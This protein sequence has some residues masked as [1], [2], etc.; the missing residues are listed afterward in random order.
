M[1][2]KEFKL[3]KLENDN[4]VVWKW[5]FKN[6]INAKGWQKAFDCGNGN[7][8]VG[9]Q[10]L[11]LLGSALS[12]ENILKI[13]N[14]GTFQEA[15]KTIESCY[16][17]KTAYEPQS[18]YRRLNSYK[19]ESAAEISS[20][21][22]EIK[23][24]VAQLQNLGETVSENCVIGSILSALPSSF[25][26]FVTV[27]RNSSEKNVD[28]LVSKLMAE[29]NDQ[30]L[31]NTEEVK[32]LAAK[33]KGR[34]RFDKNQCRY[35]KQSGHWIK[36][37]PN[38][39]TP[40]DPNRNKNKNGQ[41]K[42]KKGEDNKEDPDLAFMSKV[43]TNQLKS[44][45][46]WVAD[47][48]CTNHMSPF[49]H[50][51]EKLEDTE[52]GEENISLA[53]DKSN[54]K[55]CGK[56]EI[57]T[58]KGRLKDVWYVPELGQ[59]LFSISAAAAN[60][61]TH[62]G[63]KEKLTFFYGNRE[64]FSA[65]LKNKL[66]LIRL[67][68]KELLKATANSATLKEWHDRFSHVPTSV[69]KYMQ[70]HKIVEDL[71][72]V[73]Q[74]KDKCED[75]QLNK[76]TKAHHP[77]RTTSKAR[78]A[79]NVLH[80]D[81]AGPSNVQSRS[82]SKY[83]VLCKDEASRYRQVA[84]VET[85][86]QIKDKVKKFIS[87]TMLETG[88]QV[89]K[90]VTDNGSEYVNRELDSYLQG[91]GIIHE[92]SVPYVPAQNGY[93]EREIRTIKE[94]AKT[95]LN[96]SK[97]N[98]NLWPEAISCAVYSLN[99]TINS[100]NNLRTPYEMWF[101]TKPSVKN[102]RIFGQLAILRQPD[103][104]KTTTWHQ[105]GVKAAFLGYTDRVNTYR[106][107]VNDKVIV[108][109]DARFMNQMYNS[110]PRKQV[111]R[112]EI[113]FWVSGENLTEVEL[114]LNPNEAERTVS[115]Q[116]SVAQS[117]NVEVI[118][119][120]SV[121]NDT[122]FETVLSNQPI[123]STPLP[124]VNVTNQQSQ[125]QEKLS[126]DEIQMF[127]NTYPDKIVEFQ[128]GNTNQTIRMKDIQFYSGTYNWKN[129]KNGQF[130][131]NQVLRQI[132]DQ[133]LG[134][135]ANTARAMLATCVSIPTTYKEAVNSEQ[136]ADW[137]AA[138]NEEMNS[139]IKNEVFEVVPEAGI[140]KKVVGSR[141]VYTIKYKPND[142]I[143][144]FKARIV[145]K[146]YT[147]RYGIDYLET[148][149][150]V[151]HV[152][153]IRLILSY[154][155]MKRLHMRQFDVKTAFLYG[156]LNE[157]IF[158]LPPEG[159][160]Q[161]NTVWKL[162]RSMYGLK[163]SPRMWNERFRKFM[164]NLGLQMSNY[165]NS[166]FYQLQPILIVI[167]YVD[168]GVI[169]AENETD[170]TRILSELEN[171]F[172]M[173]KLE[174]NI[175]RGIQIVIQEDGIFIH[176]AKYAHKVLKTFNMLDANKANNPVIMFMAEETLLDGSVPYRNAVGSL[177]YLA[178][179]TRPDIA[180]AVNQLT[181]KSAAPTTSD[182]KK[183][184]HVLRYLKG[185]PNLGIKFKSEVISENLIGYCDS[186]FSGCV[187]TSKSTT[188]YVILFNNSPFHWKTQLQKHVTLSSTEAEVIALCALSKELSW[189]R[190][191]IMELGMLNENRAII[192]CDNQSAITI[193]KSERATTRTRHLRAQDAYVREQIELQELE[194][195]HVKTDLQLADLLTKC[196]NTRKF[197][198]NCDKLLTM[199]E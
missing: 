25:D 71:N 89:L 52:H 85:K 130:L 79:G 146:G 159:Y 62:V 50:L 147:Q 33:Y 121:N 156:Q 19:I 131:S 68:P 55:V 133:V 122:Q 41:G 182:W 73:T 26:I 109:C 183:V 110:E 112:E 38:L 185:T 193:A 40:Y 120:L 161:P 98:E 69:I 28:S 160:T 137:K 72:I 124:G 81:T 123:S 108:S 139:M 195:K 142:E 140:A 184:K 11:G 104:S 169:F 132:R 106:F 134:S 54:L 44:E 179:T 162:K 198:E 114:D 31:K 12:N 171:E 36:D 49:K 7:E 113:D 173:R 172:E 154:A 23:G 24:I 80:L 13:I 17:N 99:R 186:D 141:W 75:C 53:D 64:L 181:R 27:W 87:K 22:S 117:T 199:L 61:L 20:G 88:N 127:I 83:F 196:V 151:V 165:D 46:I 35:C 97:L 37:C 32:A 84:F 8:M 18:L 10:A 115:Q 197:K 107:L 39:K 57:I 105:K 163:Q 63:G 2:D 58:R 95:M 155:A 188:G 70:K 194:L 170:I 138:M 59:N 66:Y 153:S 118:Q 189:I 47:S 48:G 67:E 42:A 1:G 128:Q 116:D 34:A 157:E 143:E 102:M 65:I 103:R 86:D 119:D 94:A 175:Y 100:T 5:Q 3:I 150:S 144:K 4:Y 176:Q 82:K 76:C 101:K 15:W 51:F 77:T 164:V 177:S 136:K 148:Y 96:K 168:D 29:A 9:R 152:M 93:I 30:T 43:S 190:R 180:F 167:V 74:S 16:E 91:R 166:V 125:N 191:M 149:C 60:G 14:C 21:V 126:N 178:D 145:A 90:I 111:E 158:M 187:E 174:V 192:L 45:E 129:T 56:G 135:Q 78:Q 92:V 6:I